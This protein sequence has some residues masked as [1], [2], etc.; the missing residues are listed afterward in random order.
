MSLPKV[1]L[2]IIIGFIFHSA[3]SSYKTTVE[4]LSIATHT[5]PLLNEVSES[6]NLAAVKHHI[7]SVVVNEN[8]T[9]YKSMLSRSAYLGKFESCTNLTLLDTGSN[10]SSD[11][12]IMQGNCAFTNGKARLTFVIS[13][14]NDLKKLQHFVVAPEGA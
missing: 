3:H 8:I 4:L 2:I 7:N 9:F 1:A 6:W 10:V 13:Y 11:M 12:K 14:E 5:V